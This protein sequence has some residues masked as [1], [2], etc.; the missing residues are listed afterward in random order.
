MKLTGG[1]LRRTANAAEKDR[2]AV[3]GQP[4]H[5]R[6]MAPRFSKFIL[7]LRV[8]SKDN[9]SAKFLMHIT[10]REQNISQS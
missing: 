1:E 4:R 6:V 5:P 2:A 10:Y 9:I 3:R 8:K 7:P